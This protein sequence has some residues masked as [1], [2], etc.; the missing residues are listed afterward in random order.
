MYDN[1]LMKCPQGDVLSTISLKKAH[2]YIRK[3][4]AEW[5]TADE[6]AIRLLFQPNTK[7]SIDTEQAR[8]VKYNQSIK[9]NCCVACGCDKDYRRH[10]IVPYAYRARFPPEFKT[11]MPHDVVIL[12]PTCHV[13]AQTAAQTRMHALEDELRTKWTDPNV[14]SRHATF[15]DP[16]IQTTRSAASALLN[17]KAQLPS[18]KVLEY[19]HV[20]R[21]YFD[22]SN[23]ND[24]M[25]VTEEQLQLASQL[26][27]RCPNPHFLSGPDL[28][29]REL[30]QAAR[31]RG[32]D[33]VIMDFVKEWR[34]LFLRTVQPQFLPP[35]WSLDTPVRC[36]SRSSSN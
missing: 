30:F 23:N 3:N 26:E 20:V 34:C 18:E 29:E 25:Q 7:R 8:L 16:T 36:E 33:S 6:T 27:P 1:I 4:L 9:H 21:D 24:S 35:G 12:C 5:E 31:E 32:M 15:L 17:R 11:H 14:D 28:L 2:W 19:I 10:Y 22:I 13:R